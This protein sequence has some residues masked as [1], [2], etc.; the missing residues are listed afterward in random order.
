MTSTTPSGPACW[1]PCQLG[2][3]IEASLAYE[4]ETAGR[5]MQREVALAP[6]FW[7]AGQAMDTWPRG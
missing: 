6:Q 7:T 1:P 4:D 3:A 5:L 2:T